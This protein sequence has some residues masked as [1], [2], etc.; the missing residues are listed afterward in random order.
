M[1]LKQLLSSVGMLLVSGAV[2]FAANTQLTDIRVAEQ[3]NATVVTLHA[4]GAFTHT[5]YRPTDKLV[6]VDLT[7]VSAGQFADKSGSVTQTGL[8]AYH[9]LTYKGAAGAEVTRIE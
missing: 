6:L 9:V 3:G 4:N 5:E 8:S 1:R 7:G 2:A